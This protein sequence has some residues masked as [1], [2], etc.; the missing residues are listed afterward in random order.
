MSDPIIWTRLLAST[1]IL[2]SDQANTETDSHS[3]EVPKDGEHDAQKDG[4]EVNQEENDSSDSDSDSSEA[5]EGTD[6]SA[7]TSNSDGNPEP[8]IR[9]ET[10]LGTVS[11]I[12][13]TQLS[14]DGTCILTSDHGRNFSVYTIDQDILQAQ[15]PRHLKPYARLTS[16]DP[17]WAFAANPHF[18]LNDYQTSQVLVSC[19]NQYINL[20]NAIWDLS[21]PSSVPKNPDSGPT[22]IGMKLASYKLVNPLTEE[23]IAPL[24]LAYMNDGT[25]FITGSQNQISIFDLTYT[26]EPVTKIRTIP[27]SRS[28]FK[29]GGRGY[30]GYISALSISPPSVASGYGILAAGTWSRNVGL[31]DAE[32]TGEIIT[33]LS[34]PS[35]FNRDTPLNSGLKGNGITQLRFSSCG[36]YLYIA[37]RSSDALLIYDVRNFAFCLSQCVGRNALSNQKLGFDIWTNDPGGSSHEVWAG[38]VDGNMRIWKDPHTKE[39][40]VEADEAFLV[41]ERPVSGVAVHG[42]GSL[43]IAAM[44]WR[45]LDSGTSEVGM[46]SRNRSGTGL[47]QSITVGGSLDILGL[48]GY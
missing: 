45:G 1:R 22:N 14:P 24:S 31:Y 25:H 9:R 11:A 33:T 28:K 47:R 42:S 13:E 32:G 44:G 15:S 2:G 21:A 30:K 16:S 48:R 40:A 36:N 29:D 19:R 4:E 10:N 27:S 35:S 38:G 5:S 6:D 23:V 8:S 39:G 3:A 17:I 18:S 37:E 20:Y 12:Q 7:S 43:A 41:G 34:L 26:D 46:A